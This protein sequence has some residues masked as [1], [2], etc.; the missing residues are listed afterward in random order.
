MPIQFLFLE[1]LTMHQYLSADVA[2]KVIQKDM[3][4]QNIHKKVI[5]AVWEIK[6]EIKILNLFHAG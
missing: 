2:Q 3:L 4:I 5:I 6:R 1:L